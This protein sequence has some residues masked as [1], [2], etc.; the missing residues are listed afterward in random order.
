MSNFEQTVRPGSVLI[1]AQTE[2]DPCGA[3]AAKLTLLQCHAFLLSRDI[4]QQSLL[5]RLLS[6][7]TFHL[8]L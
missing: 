8:V 4:E 5:A 7:L 6:W 1:Q 3:E 2:R